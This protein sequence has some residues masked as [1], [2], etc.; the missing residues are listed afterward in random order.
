MRSG[1]LRHKVII[2]NV[3]ETT[4]SMGGS[5]EVW[6]DTEGVWAQISPLSSREYFQQQQIQSQATHRVTIRHTTNV[7]HKSR[8]KFGARYLYVQSMRNIDEIGD[9]LEL[10]CAEETQ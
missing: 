7:N 4:D 1:K 3:T 2:Q 10:M 6:S 5:T 8:L 9:K